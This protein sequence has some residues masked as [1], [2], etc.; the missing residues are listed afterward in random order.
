MTRFQTSW[1]IA[2][3][4]WAVLK[5]DKSLAWF[6]VLS[7][8]ASLAVFGVFGGLVARDRHRR[9]VDRHVAAADRLGAHRRRLPR[10]GVRA[11]VLPR[12]PRRRR[13][14]AAARGRTPPCAARSTI[15]NSRLHRLLPWAV[16]TATVTHDPQAIEERFGH[17]RP[18]SSPGSSA[19]RGTSSRSSPCRSSC[20][21][22]SASATR[23]SAPRTSSRR[24]GARTSI[25]QFGLG[26]VGFLAVLPGI[27]AHRARRRHR[28]RRRL[29]VLGAVGVVVAH[30]SAVDR[31]RRAERHLPHR[32]VPVRRPRAGAGRVRGHRLRGR[33]P[34]AS[35][36]PRRHVRRRQ[37]R[38]QP[39]LS[40]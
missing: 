12:R 10:A 39:Q 35:R 2:K 28:H 19:S 7:V 30:R 6:P 27:L 5:S 32:A 40:R 26:F 22:T 20:S 9:H 24:P 38:H 31:R 1:E 37:R 25:G 16:V 17:R 18:R 4:S 13:R 14:P 11:D 8:L 15:A 21:R 34:A 36:Q 3:R 29:I 33:V 23:S